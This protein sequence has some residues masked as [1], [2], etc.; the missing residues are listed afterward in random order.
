LPPPCRMQNGVPPEAAASSLPARNAC[1]RHDHRR[2]GCIASALELPADPC[3]QGCG[4]AN[5]PS[6]RLRAG[7]IWRVFL[8]ALPASR[9]PPARHELRG[10]ARPI[11]GGRLELRMSMTSTE[12]PTSGS[13]T[14]NRGSQHSCT[15]LPPQQ[16]QPCR[17]YGDGRCA[18]LLTPCSAQRRL[19]CHS[20]A[21][22]R[23]GDRSSPGC[24][25]RSRRRFLLSR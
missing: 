6:R 19:I 21:A 9:W 16:N 15:L 8:G 1:R 18:R 2:A 17:P 10:K 22:H 13:A 4:K 5:R 23:S 25:S 24:W 11:S 14:N 20:L 7:R 3:P 12:E